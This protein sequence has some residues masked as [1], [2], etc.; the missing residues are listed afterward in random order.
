[1][2]WP[3]SSGC[4]L[5][6]RARP[7]CRFT[8][9]EDDALFRE[10]SGVSADV[11]VRW[12]A[13]PRSARLRCSP[14]AWPFRAGNVADILLL[15]APHADRMSISC[16]MR[17]PT[18]CS[19]K[20]ASGPAPLCGARWARRLPERLADALL[21]RMGCEGDLG[22]L[23]DK[24]LRAT[25]SRAC[26]LGIFADRHRRLRQGRSH[27]R[28]HFHRRPV[29]AD[30]GGA[31]CLPGLYAIGEAVDVTGWLGGYNFQWAW[32]SG[33]AAGEAV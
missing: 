8:L 33:R 17:Q 1:M 29:I 7:W 32:A 27:R 9:G 18:G 4:Q 5:C 11:S 6:S 10:L 16:P 12:Q 25:Q 31:P 30:H 22:N 19:P 26:R 14:I 15:A 24:A 23:S 13:R 28:R 21:V 20:S 3:A 2:R